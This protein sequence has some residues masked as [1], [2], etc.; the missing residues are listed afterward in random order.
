MTIKEAQEA[1]DKWIKEMRLTMM[2]ILFFISFDFTKNEYCGSFT[3]L[4][5]ESRGA[6]EGETSRQLYLQRPV[7]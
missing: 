1:V 2:I 4:G 5:Y 6:I 7:L 3:L